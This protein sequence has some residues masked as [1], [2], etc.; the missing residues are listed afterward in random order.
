MIRIK[1]DLF[2]DV[3]N[4]TIS[5]KSILELLTSKFWALNEK[6]YAY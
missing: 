2:A 3:V 1:Y 5:W 6:Y 4:E